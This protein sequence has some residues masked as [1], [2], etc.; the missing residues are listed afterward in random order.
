MFQGEPVRWKQILSIAIL[1]FLA[2]HVAL[3]LEMRVTPLLIEPVVEASCMGASHQ[4]M[5]LGQ[6]FKLTS[7]GEIGP[8]EVSVYWKS[9]PQSRGV[10]GVYQMPESEKFEEEFRIPWLASGLTIFTMSRQATTSDE[11]VFSSSSTFVLPFPWIDLDGDG[12]AIW[13]DESW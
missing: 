9:G 2:P 4:Y 5:F 7:L 11:K 8:S 6:S 1:L 12:L 13:C 3:A 10:L